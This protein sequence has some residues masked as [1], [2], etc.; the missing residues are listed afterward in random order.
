M[1]LDTREKKN[2]E[3]PDPWVVFL[4]QLSFEEASLSNQLPKTSF[5]SSPFDVSALFPHGNPLGAREFRAIGSGFRTP[6]SA[7]NAHQGL[8]RRGGSL[9]Q[10]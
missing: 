9:L 5:K 1:F 8:Q 7:G 10:H 4:S 3:H 6:H 2:G